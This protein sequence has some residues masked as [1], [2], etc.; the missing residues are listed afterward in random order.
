MELNN[1]I[2]KTKIEQHLKN[3]NLDNNHQL[4]FTQQRRTTDSVYILS[5][6]IEQ[7]YKKKQTNYTIN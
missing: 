2:Q 4:G 1:T 5:C 7:S 6:I 3:N